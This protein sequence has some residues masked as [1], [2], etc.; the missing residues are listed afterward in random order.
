M[1]EMDPN[2]ISL[3][4]WQHVSTFV[5]YIWLFVLS[6]VIFAA[7]MLIGHNA[8][9]SLI[10]SQHIPSSLNKARVPFYGVSIVAFVAAVIFVLLAFQGGRAAIKL[11]YPEFWI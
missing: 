8:I 2:Y 6:M 1:F 3:E 9:P 11:I 7:N 10:K 4:A 5:T